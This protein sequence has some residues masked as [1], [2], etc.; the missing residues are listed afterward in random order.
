MKTL[1]ISDE[2]HKKLKIFCAE[3]DFKINELVEKIIL[4]LINEYEK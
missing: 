3:N 1:K 2:V 4:E